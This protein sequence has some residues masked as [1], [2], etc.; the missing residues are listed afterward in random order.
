MPTMTPEYLILL[1]G[2]GMGLVE[3]AGILMGAFGIACLCS[4]RVRNWA[5]GRPQEHKQ[6]KPWL[7]YQWRPHDD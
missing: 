2:I 1:K 3:F 5:E 7:T 4:K 6:Q